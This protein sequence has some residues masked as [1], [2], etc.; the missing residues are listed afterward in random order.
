MKSY[1]LFAVLVSATAGAQIEW[2]QTEV[3]LKVHPTQISAEAVFEFTNTGD[4]PVSF[5]DIG[6]SCGCLST[7]PL[8]KS[9]ASGESG[10]LVV[11]YNLRNRVG[12]Q[13]KHIRADV[14]DGQHADLSISVNIPPSYIVEPRL[15]HWRKGDDAAQKTIRLRNPNA[16][17]IQLLSLKSSHEGLPAELKTIRDGFEYEVVVSRLPGAV[18]ARSVIRIETEPP[19][20]LNESKIINLYVFAR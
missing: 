1:I 9:Y 19:P 13:R 3:E 16:L 10:R 4:E 2:K 20:G 6:I 15:L 14:S 17:P 5:S 18:N 12:S 11:M 8:K 7:K